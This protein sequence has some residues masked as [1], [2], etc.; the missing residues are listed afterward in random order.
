MFTDEV[1][2]DTELFFINSLY[3]STSWKSAFDKTRS[4]QRNFDIN[5]NETIKQTVMYNTDFVSYYIQLKELN[6]SAFI[7]EF[8]VL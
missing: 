4:K 3:F 7:I 5:K 1:S 8:K 6:I 2:A